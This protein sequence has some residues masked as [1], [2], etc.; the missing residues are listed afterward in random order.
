MHGKRVRNKECQIK[1]DRSKNRGKVK[2]IRAVRMWLEPKGVSKLHVLRRSAGR[3]SRHA[4]GRLGASR[5]HGSQYQMIRICLCNYDYTQTLSGLRREA[6]QI[7]TDHVLVSPRYTIQVV[8]QTLLQD[9]RLCSGCEQQASC[10]VALGV[11]AYTA[12][13]SVI[14]HVSSPCDHPWDIQHSPSAPSAFIMVC[15]PSHYFY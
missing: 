7:V 6:S 8:T 12:S 15:I 5:L 4:P 1:K 3:R 13:R 10:V 9:Y 2:A 11:H 14:L